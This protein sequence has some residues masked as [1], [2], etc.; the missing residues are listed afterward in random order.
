VNGLYGLIFPMLKAIGLVALVGAIARGSV[1][2]GSW[3]TA[4]RH[5]LVGVEPREREA[6]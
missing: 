1:A 2:F 5:R 6:S 4:F 3:R